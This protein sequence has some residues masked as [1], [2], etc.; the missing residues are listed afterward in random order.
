MSH[1]VEFSQLKRKKPILE[2]INETKPV[3][4]CFSESAQK[5]L[6]GTTDINQAKKYCIDNNCFISK[7]PPGTYTE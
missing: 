1:S 2:L 7:Y 6:F 3:Y 4:I 5:A